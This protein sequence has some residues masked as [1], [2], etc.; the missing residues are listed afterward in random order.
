MDSYQFFMD[1]MSAIFQVESYELDANSRQ[2]V[3]N[4]Y[5][6]R[7]NSYLQAK[8]IIDNSRRGRDLIIRDYN[9]NM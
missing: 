1:N 3:N 6:N 7:K 5:N 9:A 4:N 8:E 2:N